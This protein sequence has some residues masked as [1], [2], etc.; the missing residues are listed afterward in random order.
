MTSRPFAL[1]IY[2]FAIASAATISPASAIDCSRATGAV[3][4]A[5]CADNGLR[6]WD[7]RF[8]W[9]YSNLLDRL[10]VRQRQELIE[11]Q[12]LWL[13]GRDSLCK[14]KPSA[15]LADCVSKAM[16]RRENEL[17]TKFSG[18]FSFGEVRL[19]KAGQTLMVGNERLDVSGQSGD[20]LNLIHGNTLIAESQAPFAIDGRGGDDSGEAVVISTHDY[21]NL[22]CSDQYL[23]AALPNQP[24]RVQALNEVDS[25][26]LSFSVRKIGNRLELSTPALPGRDGLV[27]EWSPKSGL[28][29]ELGTKF[30]P[31]HGTTMAD[32]PGDGAPTDNEEF[33]NS[34]KR[35]APRDWRSIAQALQSASVGENDNYLLM[36]TCSGRRGCPTENAFAAYAKASK[37]F[38]FAYELPGSKY[39]DD[40][41]QQIIYYP[42]RAKWPADLAELVDEWVNEH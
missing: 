12:K 25:C 16:I 15:D 22:G 42:E 19:G 28:I 20:I 32:F 37:T 14:T 11:S 30:S 6:K 1:N 13:I 3:E 39:K 10:D 38:F 17:A 2:A 7:E 9:G 36:S 31:K 5:I 35:I 23:V 33:Y 27:R 24:L 18:G 29:I 41:A 8:N 40:H 4:T 34:I 26:G 21:G